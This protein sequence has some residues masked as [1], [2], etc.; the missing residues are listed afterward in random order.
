MPLSNRFEVGKAY[1]AKAMIT[2]CCG[3]NGCL[4]KPTTVDLVVKK[5]SKSSVYLKPVKEMSDKK[6]S[7]TIFKKCKVYEGHYFKVRLTDTA[8]PLKRSVETCVYTNDL[9]EEDDVPLSLWNDVSY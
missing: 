8:D 9:L 1:R 3:L 5:K 4:C 6:P 2:P 7:S